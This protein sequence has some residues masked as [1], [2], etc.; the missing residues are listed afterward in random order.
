MASK[1]R[2]EPGEDFRGSPLCLLLKLGASDRGAAGDHLLFFALDFNP[3]S[4][5]SGNAGK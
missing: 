1:R 2:G 3:V 5:F 4:T